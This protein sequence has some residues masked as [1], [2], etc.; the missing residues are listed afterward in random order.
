MKHRSTTPVSKSFVAKA[1]LVAAAVLMAISGP[2]QMGTVA[3]ADQYD[4]KINAIRK[5]VNAYQDEANKL[6]GEANTLQAKVD[7]LSNEASAIQKQIDLN[8]V[9]YDQL[10]AQIAA[11]EKKIV[12]NQDALGETLASLYVDDDISP[13]EMLASSSNI[14]EYLDKQEYRNSIR[15]T[16]SQKIGEI[17]QLKKDLDKKRTNVE[18]VLAE[19]KAQHEILAG[20]KAEQQKLLND[21]KGNEAAY[22]L[23][24]STSQAE[25]QK[26]QA[27]QQA[28]YA[29]ARA[30]WGGGYI[31]STDTSGYPY[32]NAYWNRSIGYSTVVDE[33]ALYARQCTS[34]VAWK[35]SSQGYGVRPFNWQGSPRGNANEW[36][37]TVSYSVQQTTGV[38]HVGDAAVM[39]NIDG[40]Y[41]TGHVMY[42]ESINGDGSI[43]ISEYNF[44]APGEYSERTIPRSSYGWW[45][46]IT[47]P[48]R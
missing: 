38:P 2:V 7:Q 11:T 48:R 33:W 5:Q 6:R 28:A 35:L 41:T 27:E 39:S 25:M 17:K 37:S 18:K 16:L 32:A 4:D 13:L 1:S 10:I 15:D 14:S 29:R 31:N 9:R 23:L 24:I 40:D 19:Q 26:I 3:R 43:N 46:F 22:Q 47:F 21:T 36:P 42:V 45:T 44:R 34:Y 20:K 12:N 8:Q 30:A